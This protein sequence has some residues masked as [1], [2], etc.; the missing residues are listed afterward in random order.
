MFKQPLLADTLS[1]LDSFYAGEAARVLASDFAASGGHVTEEDLAAFF[2]AE[3]GKK[4]GRLR[5]GL[6]E[7]VDRAPELVADGILKVRKSGRQLSAA[8]T[9]GA[10]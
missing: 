4:V 6:R 5:R 1:R 7:F 9:I 10:I 8:R 3:Y 2:V